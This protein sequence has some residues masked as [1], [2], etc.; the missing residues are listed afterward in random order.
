MKVFKKPIPKSPLVYPAAV[1]S[2][3]SLAWTTWS[4]V[5]LLGTGLIGITV[6]AGADLIWASVI[7]AEARGLRIASRRWAVPAVGWAAV[8]VVAAFLV[9]HGQASGIPA[10]AAAGPFLPLG[11]KGVWALALADMRDPAALTDDQL[12]ALADMDRCMTFEEAQH[13]MEMRRRTMR[14]ELLLAEVSTDFE[15][16][17]T[18][19]EKARELHRRRP[20]ELPAAEAPAG[21]REIFASVVADTSPPGDANDADHSTSSCEIFGFGAALAE[22]AP[23]SETPTP[24]AT[25]ISFRPQ[26]KTSPARTAKRKAKGRTQDPRTAA[27][28]EYLASVRAGRPLTGAELGRRYGRTPRWGQQLIAEAKDA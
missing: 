4:L 9:W 13:R 24:A 18:R 20:L 11:A 5:D 16:E 10:M 14:G 23:R 8:A 2:A 17:L 7:V 15:V 3:A 6:A 22:P 21:Q 27:V 28:T 26:A 19:Q 12:H 1:L 25:G